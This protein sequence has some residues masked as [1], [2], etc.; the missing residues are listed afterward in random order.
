MDLLRPVACVIWPEGGA[1][2]ESLL[3]FYDDTGDLRFQRGDPTLLGRTRQAGVV[4]RRV[5]LG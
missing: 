5:P 1:C 3:D 2:D 4:S